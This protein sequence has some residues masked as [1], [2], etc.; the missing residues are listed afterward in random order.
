MLDDLAR[1]YRF[2]ALG[3]ASFMPPPKV[4]KHCPLPVPIRRAILDVKREDP[5]LNISEIR[6][7]CWA[8]IVPRPSNATVGRVLAE[9]PPPSYTPSSPGLKHAKTRPGGR[10]VGGSRR[11]T[12]RRSGCTAR[13][14]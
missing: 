9:E 13:A 1:V 3:V 6:T 4:E 7:I 8:R 10:G 12:E 2:E 14:P 11:C 5:P